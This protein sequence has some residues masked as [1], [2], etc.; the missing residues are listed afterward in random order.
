MQ[1][2]R[3]FKVGI[4]RSDGNIEE[5][6][7]IGEIKEIELTAEDDKVDK[8]DYYKDFTFTFDI[9]DNF[10]RIGRIFN[11]MNNVRKFRGI[12]MRRVKAFEKAHK[13]R[14]R[15]SRIKTQQ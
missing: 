9:T 8:I 7:D 15:C 6:C 5:L 12:P 1:Q 13:L 4:K 2:N 14:S 10:N 11:V 3:N